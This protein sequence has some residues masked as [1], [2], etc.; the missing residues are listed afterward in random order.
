MGVLSPGP[1]I[2]LILAI[3]TRQGQFPSLV[4]AFGIAC[5][6]IALSTATAY[7]LAAIMAQMSD[8]MT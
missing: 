6:S 4:T 8:V 5:A 2:R 7:G 3:A 1:A